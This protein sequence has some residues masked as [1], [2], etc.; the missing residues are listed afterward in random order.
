[1]YERRTTILSCEWHVREE[2]DKPSRELHVRM[3][4][5]DTF[6]RMARK[7]GGGRNLFANGTKERRTTILSREWDVRVEDNETLT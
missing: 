7:R 2:D 1:M 3:E 6:P 5:D 4:D